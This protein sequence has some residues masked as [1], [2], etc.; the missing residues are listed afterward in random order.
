[1]TILPII[2]KG[3]CHEAPVEERLKPQEIG[4]A[5]FTLP[6]LNNIIL[7]KNMSAILFT[8]ALFD[9]YPQLMPSI[10]SNGYNILP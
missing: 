4:N 6:W 2:D 3:K 9:S 10:I 5:L 8:K 1:M 7:F